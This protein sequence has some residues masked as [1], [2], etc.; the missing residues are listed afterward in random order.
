MS[1]F[2]TSVQVFL[3]PVLHF[4]KDETVTEIMINGP[5]DIFIERKGIVEKTT[6]KFE[7]ENSLLAAVRNI[8]QFVGRPID[9]EHPFLDARLPDG[10]RIHAV[11]SPI[12]K[13]GTTVAI[14]KFF[15]EKLAL[16]D[17]IAKGALTPDAARF[18]DVCLYLKKNIMISGGTGSGKTTFLNVLASRCLPSQR[19]VVLEDSSELKIP[20]EHVVY[21]EARPA[22]E[23][24]KGLVTLRDL[25]KSSLRLRPDRVIVGEVRGA[26]ALDL[27]SSMNTGHSGSMG[28][29]HSNNPRESLTRLETLA[30]MSETEVPVTAIRAQVAAAINIVIQLSRLADGSRKVTHISEGLGMDLQG[31]YQTQD[32]YLFEQTGRDKDGKVLGELRPC[33]NIPSFMREIE[34]NRLPFTKEML[35]KRNGST[36]PPP[37]KSENHAA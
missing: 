15:K 21:F 37:P 36:T 28:T 32:I 8:S 13:N 24:G 5:F 14:R 6:A 17:L 16:K 7:D 10:S 22:N 26:E 19:I 29:V 34:V 30:L 3:K 31:N 23:Q 12:A 35:M 27:I 2:E 33:G 18:L 11:V 4:L 25:V 20:N 9:E 1:V